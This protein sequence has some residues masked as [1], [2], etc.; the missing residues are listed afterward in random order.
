MRLIERVA[1]SV[2]ET[3]VLRSEWG[4][5]LAGESV[6]RPVMPKQWGVDAL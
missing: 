5:E 6:G 1:Q 2:A 4:L 3:H